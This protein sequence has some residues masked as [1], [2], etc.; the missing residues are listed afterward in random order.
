M[1]NYGCMVCSRGG[2]GRGGGGGAWMVILSHIF[3]GV[4][5]KVSNSVYQVT[6]SSLGMEFH[7]PHATS[8][9]LDAP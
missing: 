7:H 1:Q 2:G 9:Y 4:S 5:E 8:M 3:L 6:P